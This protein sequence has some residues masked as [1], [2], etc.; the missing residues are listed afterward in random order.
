MQ[1]QCV[2]Y[3]GSQRPSLFFVPGFF[4][5]PLIS[6]SP[7]D[8]SWDTQVSK[9]AQNYN[10][11]GFVVRWPAGNIFDI[12]LFQS[13]THAKSAIQSAIKSW[14]GARNRSGIVAQAL[15]EHLQNVEGPIHIAGHSLGGRIV[16]K[17]AESI[18]KP[19]YLAS[20]TALAPAIS[21]QEIDLEKTAEAVHR[22]PLICHSSKDRVLSSIFPYGQNPH[23]VLTLCNQP[24]SGARSLLRQL[25][26]LLE[27]R[28]TNPAIGF[29]GVPP[30]SQHLFNSKDTQLRHFK[31]TGRFYNILSNSR[32]LEP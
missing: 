21:V 11:N 1:I 8:Q 22:P 3:A 15:T 18:N 16:L 7:I 12:S 30:E 13:S 27:S 19:H 26:S 17:V 14:C 5:Q 6:G 23:Q 25:S 20:V 32:N 4:T 29:V 9:V 2:H 10:I 31:Y 28:Y 24:F